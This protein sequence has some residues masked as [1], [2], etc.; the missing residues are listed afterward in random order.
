MIAFVHGVPETAA[1]WRA[2]QERI[3]RPSVALALP[4]F[5]VPRPQGFCATRDALLVG[6]MVH[7]LL[8]RF[9]MTIDVDDAE[10]AAVVTEILR[11]EHSERASDR[12][13]IGDVVA[14]FRAL[15]NLAELQAH[16]KTGAIY[17]EVPFSFSTGGQ[18]IRGAIDCLIRQEDGSIRILEFKTGRRRDE[19]QRQAEIYRRAAEA[20]FS[21]QVVAVD[22][23]YALDVA[24]S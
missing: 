5:G 22:V 19:H 4:G 1:L 3:D 23:L 9:G 17:H 15:R 12:A 16:Y 18:I 20:I 21:E 13:I 24:Q 11:R 7:R 10:L 14:R 8:Q 6:L 2:V